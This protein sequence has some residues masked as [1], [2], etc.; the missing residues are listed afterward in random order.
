MG[1]PLIEEFERLNYYRMRKEQMSNVDKERLMDL[2][3][4]HGSDLE[5]GHF[6]KDRRRAI[7][8]QKAAQHLHQL[9]VGAGAKARES[10]H[11]AHTGVIIRKVKIKGYVVDNKEDILGKKKPKKGTKKFTSEKDRQNTLRRAEALQ[12]SS[13]AE[14]QALIQI[15]AAGKA[16]ESAALQHFEELEKHVQARDA[17]KE[18]AEE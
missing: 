11:G 12:E 3:R 9:A 14:A 10:L 18:A 5:I 6:T 17:L 13:R 16:A 2:Q 8:I 15:Q 4:R 1:D 7:E